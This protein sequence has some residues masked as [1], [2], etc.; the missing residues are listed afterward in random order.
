[1]DE[2]GGANQSTL[3][4]RRHQLLAFCISLSCTHTPTAWIFFLT[5]ST[6]SLSFTANIKLHSPLYTGWWRNTVFW[7]YT[8]HFHIYDC[9]QPPHIQNYKLACYYV[10]ETWSLTL[11][12][13]RRLT[14][15]SLGCWGIY[16]GLRG[17]R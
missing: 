17:T 14:V 9:L 3:S 12:E 4:H 16:S 5:A 1:M 8:P 11:R 6:K 7:V 13:E 10:R 15:Y 2:G